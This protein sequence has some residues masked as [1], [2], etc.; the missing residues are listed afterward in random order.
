MNKAER[1]EVGKAI[2]ILELEIEYA[3][4]NSWYD[5]DI[6]VSEEWIRE[7]VKKLKAISNKMEVDNHE[8]T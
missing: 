3:E 1:E 7:A 2:K 6:T 4:R 8:R 5:D